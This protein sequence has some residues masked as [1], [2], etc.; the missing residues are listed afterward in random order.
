MPLKIFTVLGLPWS[1]YH[2]ALND[3]FLASFPKSYA[4]PSGGVMVL[5]LALGQGFILFGDKYGV[6]G[7]ENWPARYA[8]GRQL[9]HPALLR[10]P[11]TVAASEAHARWL[12]FV[13]F[14]NR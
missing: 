13:Q 11:A 4:S 7:A 12:S 1:P 8:H 9:G 14:R 6:L 5:T 2:P 10:T 3:R